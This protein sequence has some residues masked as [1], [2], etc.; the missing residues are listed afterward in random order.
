VGPTC[1]PAGER[2]KGGGPTD[3]FVGR[4]RR[5]GRGRKGKKGESEVGRGP[6]EGG[7]EEE[8]V[9]DFGFFFFFKSFLKNF[10]KPF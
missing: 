6:K 2:E 8:R 3:A 10:S 5:A 9:W 4:K 1:Q 7:R